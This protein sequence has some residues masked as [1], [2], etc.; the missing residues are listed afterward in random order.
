MVILNDKAIEYMK[1]K[2]FRDIL[3]RTETV[4]S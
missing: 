2:G 3:L 4:T 1:K